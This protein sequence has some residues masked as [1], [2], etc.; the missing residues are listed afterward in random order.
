MLGARIQKFG[1]D[2]A[3]N[4][5]IVE[6]LRAKGAGPQTLAAIQA[7][8]PRSEVQLSAGLKQYPRVS[9]ADFK[10]H[11]YKQDD[12]FDTG[13]PITND[14]YLA[15]IP[16]SNTRSVQV[17]IGK[18]IVDPPTDRPNVFIY[19]VSKERSQSDTRLKGSHDVIIPEKSI[20]HPLKV[21]VLPSDGTPDEVSFVIRLTIPGNPAQ[22]ELST[23]LQREEE[24]L[25]AYEAKHPVQASQLP[26][27]AA[28]QKATATHF[29]AQTEVSGLT[30]TD[31]ATGLMWAKSDNGSDVNW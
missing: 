26:A 20:L 29:P 25:R 19:L 21:R 27:P 28:I 10:V 1:V 30:W 2:F 12:W 18:T 22:G 11:L 31:P 24:A 9:Q 4:P 6:S 7:L 17:M 15:L 3:P 14:L 8:L 13:I 16:P 5:A 23:V